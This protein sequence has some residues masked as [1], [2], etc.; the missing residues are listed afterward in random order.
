MGHRLEVHPYETP[1]GPG[2]YTEMSGIR[3]LLKTTKP[4]PATVL[5]TRT[6]PSSTEA[7]R[8]H[9]NNIKDDYWI[10]G[11]TVTHDFETATD[12]AT[13]RSWSPTSSR[14]PAADQVLEICFNFTFSL[15]RR[16]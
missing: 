12:C 14:I 3:G 1:F 5:L 16:N 2:R 6:S 13:W 15:P 9:S 8:G 4:S 7:Q 11:V 10:V